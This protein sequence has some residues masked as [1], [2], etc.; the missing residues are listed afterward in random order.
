MRTRQRFFASRPGAGAGNFFW[1]DLGLDPAIAHTAIKTRKCN[2]I[3]ERYYKTP[4]PLM[5]EIVVGV[6]QSFSLKSHQV[7]PSPGFLRRVSPPE[8]LHALIMAIH[9]DVKSEEVEK[10]RQWRGILLNTLLSFEIIEKDS[11]LHHKNTQ[12]RERSGIEHELIRHSSL[13]RCLD[14]ANFSARMQATK[15]KKSERGKASWARQVSEAYNADLVLSELSEKV[16]ESFVER[17]LAVSSRM[18]KSSG[19]GQAALLG[20]CVWQQWALG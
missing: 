18:L 13:S 2:E 6:S 19:A 20:R 14:V 17:S 9:R 11:S 12:L 5:S 1:V 8:P 15:L 10:L 16:T 4:K 3:A 7:A